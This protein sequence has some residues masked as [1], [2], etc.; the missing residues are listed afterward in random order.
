MDCGGSWLLQWLE[1][2]NEVSDWKLIDGS[3]GGVALR[4]G[5]GS[6]NSPAFV[7]VTAEFGD[8]WSLP[9]C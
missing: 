1:T 5:A 3:V 7:E 2:F 4:V 8:E 9:T 6:G